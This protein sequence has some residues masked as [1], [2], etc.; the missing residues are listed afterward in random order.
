M[1]AASGV[2][3]CGRDGRVLV[4]EPVYKDTWEIPGG[5]VEPGE[6]PRQTCRREVAEELGLDVV[7]GALL[8]VEYA[9]PPYARWEGYRFVFDGGE[10]TGESLAA[11]RLQ[12]DELAGW[13]LITVEELEGLVA[14]PLGRRIRAALE[15]HTDGRGPRYLENGVSSASR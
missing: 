13:R 5:V 8:C 10:L 1:W 2:L 11:I 12:E 15:A 6:S 9:G 3:F 4:V 7:P 14:A